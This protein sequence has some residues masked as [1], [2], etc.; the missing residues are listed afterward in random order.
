VEAQL[1]VLERTVTA[2]SQYHKTRERQPAGLDSRTEETQQTA[3]T[4]SCYGVL[5]LDETGER[6]T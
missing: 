5:C 4:K 2:G 6:N 3:T 1:K